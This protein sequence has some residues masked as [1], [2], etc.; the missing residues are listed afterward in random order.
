MS[1]CHY[2]VDW[3]ELSMPSIRK[4]KAKDKRL[5]Q[6]DV[7]CDMENLDVMLVIYSRNDIDSQFSGTL[8]DIDQ[9]SRSDKPTPTSAVK[10]SEHFST[11]TVLVTLRLRQRQ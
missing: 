11:Q 5:G 4:Q 6:S 2:T 7:V 8:E 9:R 10:I 3:T 1:R